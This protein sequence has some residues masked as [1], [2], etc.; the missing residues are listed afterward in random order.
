MTANGMNG[1]GLPAAWAGL[2]QWRVL[3]TGFGRGSNFLAAWHAWKEDPRRP[4]LLHYVAIEASPVSAADLLR[5][6]EGRPELEPLARDL[7]AQW[8]GLMPGIHRLAFERGRVLLTLHVTDVNDALRHERF[9]ADSVFIEGFG[10][11]NLKALARHC[12]RGTR[13]AVSIASGELREGLAQ[14]GFQVDEA[15]GNLQG[16]FAPAWVPK[17]TRPAAPVAPSRCVVIGA[18]LA[19]A[20]V[21]ASLARRGWQVTVLDAATQPAAGASGVPVGMLAPHYSPDDNLLSRLSRTGVRLAMQQARE[22]LREGEDWKATG[23]LERR[24]EPARGLTEAGAPW[25]RTATAQELAE[26]ALPEHQAAVWHE[27][28]AWI[29]PGAMVAAWLRQP[30]IEWQG[31]TK[32]A[33]A[34]R[35]AEDWQLLDSQGK[36]LARA[37]LVVIAIALESAQVA[38]AD[39]QLLPVRGQVSWGE[40]LASAPLPSFPINGNGHFIPGVPVAGS[41]AWF[42]GSTF[43][44]GET[45]LE[46]RPQDHAA[47]LARLRAL[48]PQAAAKV[49]GA[50]DNGT[51]HAWTGVR[52]ASSNRRPLVG[53]LR[54]GLW[55]STAMGSRGLTFS[56]LCAE[57]LAARLH[58]E[59]L[60]LPSRLAQALEPPLSARRGA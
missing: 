13:I 19:G 43:D 26:A 45:A 37:P 15:D 59:P 9:V 32:V 20:A 3:E 46:V 28:A 33:R 25:S 2:R 52:C 18:G 55:V 41:Q 7:A 5:S 17:G 6:A 4:S 48:V 31:N 40:Q 58:D 21:A 54:P 42:C 8:F 51:V 44:R 34:V 35:D 57:L 30:G 53:E 16:E 12:R 1:L 49:Q 29:K 50:F 39:L 47:N 60:P 27:Q 14:V 23:V 10:P 38:G 11:H 56:V 24:E 22:L 36:V